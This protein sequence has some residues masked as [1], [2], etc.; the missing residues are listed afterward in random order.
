VEI[1]SEGLTEA[2]PNVR[3]D[4]TLILAMKHVS[5][6]GGS[7]MMEIMSEMT[8]DFKKHGKVFPLYFREYPT[9]EDGFLEPRPNLF[10]ISSV[11]NPCAWYVSQWAFAS[12][13]DPPMLDPKLAS[14]FFGDV[15]NR[16]Q[17]AAW[18][19]WAQ[20]MGGAPT[21]EAWERS[22]PG[23]IHEGVLSLRFW[24]SFVAGRSDFPQT[25]GDAGYDTSKLDAYS[26]FYMNR[27]D[28]SAGLAGF[29]PT[30]SVDC[31]V[32]DES[33]DADLRACLQEYERRSGAALDWAPFEREA[34]AR[35]EDRKI[36]HNDSEHDAC[37]SYYTPELA[38]LVQ[39]LDRPIFTRFGYGAC[40]GQA[41][42]RTALLGEGSA[43]ERARP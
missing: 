3:Q 5:K 8:H 37:G 20:G 24:E 21:P 29:S 2:E 39:E 19:R 13:F 22:H 11:R 15:H 42:F 23:T 31:W 10:V 33:Y 4:P 16:T 18:L 14:A 34:S 27:T 25:P 41:S 9:F 40:C 28:V 7:F 17:F 30:A 36:D 6:A 26:T 12:R 43:V 32:H 1:T 35:K 38:S